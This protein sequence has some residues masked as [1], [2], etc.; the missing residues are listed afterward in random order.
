[1]TRMERGLEREFYE[2]LFKKLV[3]D[4]HEALARTPPHISSHRY[5]E[6]AYRLAL[7]GYSVSLNPGMLETV[8]LKEERKS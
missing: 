4:L 5:L 6:R 7:S 8:Y 1:M 3:R 2:R